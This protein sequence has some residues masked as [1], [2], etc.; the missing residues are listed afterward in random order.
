MAE[1]Q[2]KWLKS[3]GCL[4]QNQQERGCAV[5]GRKW[6]VLGDSSKGDAD[7]NDGKTVCNVVV[8]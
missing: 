5:L 2:E 6:S 3:T 7:L 4:G 1:H 8:V